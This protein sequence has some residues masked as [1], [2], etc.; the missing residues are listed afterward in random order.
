MDRYQAPSFCPSCGKPQSSWL[1]SCRSCGQR[2]AD[3]CPVCRRAIPLG[4][5]T[6]AD[7][8]GAPIPAPIPAAV[9]EFAGQ[10]AAAPF[11]ASVP[12]P[13]PP[14]PAAGPAVGRRALSVLTAVVAFL[15]ASAGV[16]AVLHGSSNAQA[17]VAKYVSGTGDKEFFAADLQFR[18]TFP[19]LPS[20]SASNLTPDGKN[21]ALVMYTSDLG[22]AAFAV[23][24]ID[25]PRNT[26][27][28]LNLAVNGAAAAVKGHVEASHLTTF[29]GFPAAEFV[30][31]VDHG[32]YV[33]GLLV[34]ATDRLYQLHAMGKSNPPSGYDHF[35]ESFHL[36]AS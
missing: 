2:F 26:P 13:P 5:G 9:P 10:P 21:H 3:S 7:H 34:R 1:P 18:A 32:V 22:D 23:G 31:S 30:V 28:D 35:K 33:K 17:R 20:R 15:V 4:A 24:A 29:E 12:L 36:V 19:T 11:A 14:P 27:F 16:G 8:V 25:I 6:C